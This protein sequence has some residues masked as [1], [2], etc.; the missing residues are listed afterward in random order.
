MRH[1]AMLF[2]ASYDPDELT[3]LVDLEG[4]P[5]PPDLEPEVEP[6]TAA[7]TIERLSQ[8]TP[9]EL[10]PPPAACVVDDGLNAQ[11]TRHRRRRRRRHNRKKRGW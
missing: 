7:A 11:A 3:Q 9:V 8:A 2:L 5:E 1:L 4:K 6:E 10:E